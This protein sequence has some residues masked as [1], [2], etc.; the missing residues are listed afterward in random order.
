MFGWLLNS[1]GTATALATSISSTF[2]HAWCGA[3]A[4]A[5]ADFIAWSIGVSGPLVYVPP[6]A[7]T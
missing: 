4:A 6:V 7:L 2:A 3:S 5:S 1:Y